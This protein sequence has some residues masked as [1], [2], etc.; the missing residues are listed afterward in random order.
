MLLSLQT[1]AIFWGC[2][3]FA[4]GVNAGVNSLKISRLPRQR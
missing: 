2:A 4:F 1:A 3:F